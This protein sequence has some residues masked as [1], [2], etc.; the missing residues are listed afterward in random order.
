MPTLFEQAEAFRVAVLRRERAPTLRL[1]DAYADVWRRLRTDLA[2]LTAEM[3]ADA[4]VGWLLSQGRYL[5]LLSQVEQE[6]ARLAPS[7]ASD[8]TA[9]QADLVLSAQE[10]TA[11]LARLAL[12]P[13]PAGVTMSF[14]QLPT[15]ALE[16]LVGFMQDGLPLRYKLPGLAPDAVARVKKALITGVG[17]G[18]GPQAIARDMRDA[19]GGNM[20]LAV[21]IARTE[22]MYSY[23]ASSIQF[24]QA[25]SDVVE[26]WVWL[27]RRS[28]RTCSSCWG[29]DGTFHT[30]DE[31]FGSHARCCCVPTPRTK[32]W[33]QLGYDIPDRRPDLGTGAAVFAKLPAADQEHILGKAKYAAFKDGSITLADTVHVADD[34]HWGVTRQ[35]A[36]LAQ[37][38]ANAGH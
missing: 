30:N 11:E 12:G 4:D 19:L 15:R 5:S 28:S 31:P 36:S 29:M 8:I 18:Q 13:M 2:D 27:S 16:H 10:H 35:V 22:T 23:R 17:T 37:A 21:T 1:I 32:S 9:A 3:P 38:T 26:G 7:I 14:A 20:Q 25:N 24:G 34:P 33:K 6:V